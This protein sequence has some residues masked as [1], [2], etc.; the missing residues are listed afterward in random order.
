M[1][2]RKKPSSTTGMQKMKQRRMLYSAAA[3]LT[4]VVSATT[5]LRTVGGLWEHYKDRWER[6]VMRAFAHEKCVLNL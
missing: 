3:S 4:A 6:I 2:Q 1:K 5:V